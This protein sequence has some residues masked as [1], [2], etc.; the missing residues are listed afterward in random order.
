MDNF[1]QF[2]KNFLDRQSLIKKGK[3]NSKVPPLD[4]GALKRMWAKQ[5]SQA[6]SKSTLKVP[7]LRQRKTTR[8][9][10]T[11]P[12]KSSMDKSDG[13]SAGSR[14]GLSPFSRPEPSMMDEES[15]YIV[16]QEEE[17]DSE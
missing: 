13:Y 11:P 4:S 15:H 7:N 1:N 6:S 5:T 9:S 3:R 16:D 8:G 10:S 17:P 12:R 2:L 14:R